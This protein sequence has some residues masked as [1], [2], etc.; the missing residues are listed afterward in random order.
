MKYILKNWKWYNEF[1]Q[2]QEPDNI[3]DYTKEK[4]INNI[5]DLNKKNIQEYNLNKVREVEDYNKNKEKI[6]AEEHK[7]ELEEK[8]IQVLKYNELI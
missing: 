7:K 4:K 1:W 5:Q 2:E 8:T 6:I 3:I